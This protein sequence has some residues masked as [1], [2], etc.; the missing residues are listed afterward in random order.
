MPRPTTRKSTSATALS[1]QFSSMAMHGNK[2]DS[3]PR[4]TEEPAIPDR[5]VAYKSRKRAMPVRG[6]R[7]LC[8]GN[9]KGK[10]KIC[11]TPVFFIEI[12]FFTSFDRVDF[13]LFFS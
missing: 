6:D 7:I 1:S 9:L 5:P 13:G 3:A 10:M 8:L 4:V 11:V 2:H 12:F